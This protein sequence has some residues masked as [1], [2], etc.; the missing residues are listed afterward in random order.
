MVLGRQFLRPQFQ[1]FSSVRY[2]LRS[3]IF[4][5]FCLNYALFELVHFASFR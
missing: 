2:V 3:Q 4:H 5:D 1:S